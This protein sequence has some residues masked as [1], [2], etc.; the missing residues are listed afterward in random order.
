M[1][2]EGEPQ[3]VQAVVGD[4]QLADQ[5]QRQQQAEAAAAVHEEDAD[6]RLDEIPLAARH[7]GLGRSLRSG[8]LATADAHQAVAAERRH[9]KNSGRYRPLYFSASG[10]RLVSTLAGTPPTTSN[11]P[12]SLFTTACAATT[13]PRWMCDGRIMARLAIQT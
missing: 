11:S 8:H 1:R 7:F 9:Q 12:M 4:A 6:E 10:F 3:R 5:R 13:A 2:R